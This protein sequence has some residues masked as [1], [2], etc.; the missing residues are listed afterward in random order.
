MVN[1]RNLDGKNL[2][3][4]VFDLAGVENV[5]KCEQ[6]SSD[7]IR[8]KAKTATNKN[9]SNNLGSVVEAWEN[10]QAKRT[11]N[12][13]KYNSK[14]QHLNTTPAGPEGYI[15]SFCWPDGTSNSKGEVDIVVDKMMVK[16]LE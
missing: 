4:A 2:K 3:A 13:V 11:G 7:F 16:T 5:F 10:L 12:M 6:G 14:T 9:Y 8:M 15:K 1:C